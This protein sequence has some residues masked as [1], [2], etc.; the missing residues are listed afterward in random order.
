[1]NKKL[2]PQFGLCATSSL[3]RGG[4]FVMALSSSDRF[5]L[6]SEQRDDDAPVAVAVPTRVRADCIF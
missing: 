1:M 2:M 4:S 6:T 3:A 5:V